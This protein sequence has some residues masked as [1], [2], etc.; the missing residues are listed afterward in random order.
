MQELSLAA[1]RKMNFDIHKQKAT[2]L[3][4][5]HGL[6]LLHHLVQVSDARSDAFNPAVELCGVLFDIPILK[7]QDISSRAPP[8]CC[9]TIIPTA[10]CGSLI[11]LITKKW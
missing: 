2:V 1:H 7:C 10:P 9:K 3:M 8:C 11:N 5:S 6:H 4:I